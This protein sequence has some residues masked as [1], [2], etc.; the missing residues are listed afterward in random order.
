MERSEFR[1]ADDE[2]LWGPK[3]LAWFLGIGYRTAL[4][5]MA[6]PRSPAFRVG[7]LYRIRPADAR[8]FYAT[9]SQASPSRA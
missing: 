3:D 1:A 4:K 9:P 6:D 5:A 7:K 8:S 2:Q